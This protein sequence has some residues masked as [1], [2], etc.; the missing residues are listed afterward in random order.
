LFDPVEQDSTV[1]DLKISFLIDLERP[2]EEGGVT[3]RKIQV[4]KDSAG[5][6]DSHSISPVG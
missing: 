3:Y 1:I 2:Y 6:L 4:L 5:N